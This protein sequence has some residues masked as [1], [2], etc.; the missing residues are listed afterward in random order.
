MATRLIDIHAHFLT[1]AY[2]QAMSE[3]GVKT[4]D[5]FPI[6]AWDV[7]K[8][9]DDMDTNGIE[10]AILSISAPGIEFVPSSAACVLA[11][12]VNE[13]LAGFI[14]GHPR[15]FGGLALLPLPNIDGALQELE[16]AL[17]TLK[18]DGVVLFSNINGIYLGDKRLDP[19]FAELHRRKT[20][21]FVHPVA[22]PGFDIAT[23][24]FPAPA[25]EF[26]FETA[27]MMMNMIASGTVRRHPDVRMIVAHGGGAASVLAPR[28]SRNLVRFG[29]LTPA[30][31]A[32][33]VS[34]AFRWFYYDMAA[35]SH[36][37]AIDAVLTL[38]P[39]N[40]LLFGSDHPFILQNVITQGIQFI[41]SSD[42]IDEATRA[43]LC[44]E[45]ARELFPRLN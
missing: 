19:I 5:G 41:L 16:Y 44:H 30:L 7:S 9:L 27:R 36:A 37:N 10:T 40:R 33:E 32:E 22:P 43:R 39:A 35:V 38:A 25:L 2:R 6:P 13:E 26:P 34:A 8:A 14:L 31:T 28:I 4:I 18:L 42:R 15:R 11:R 24:G 1:D 29:Q 17:D 23:L 20:V 3:A 21:V 12:K 45:N